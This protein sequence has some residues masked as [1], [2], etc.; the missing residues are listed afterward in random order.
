MKSF[1]LKSWYYACAAP[2]PRHALGAAKACNITLIGYRSTEADAPAFVGQVFENVPTS[3]SPGLE[4]TSPYPE[5]RWP[6]STP[7]LPEAVQAEMEFGQFN[8]FEG[9]KR[10]TFKHTPGPGEAVILGDDIVGSVV[11]N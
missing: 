10:V 1:S 11:V 3:T 9:V 4:Y 7:T 8:G 2:P 6:T 5:S